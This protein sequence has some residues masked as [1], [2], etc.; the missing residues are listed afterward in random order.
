MKDKLKF[1]L[2]EQG[3]LPTIDNF[4]RLPQ[5][6]N[7]LVSGCRGIAPAPVKRMVIKSYLRT[8]DLNWFIETGTHL[9]DTLADVA[10]DKSLQTVSIELAD[11]YYH[12]AQKRFANYTNVEL[13]HGDSGTLMPQ[14]VARLQEPA[15]FWLDGHYSGGITA[16]GDLETPVSHELQAILASPVRG[17]VILIDD[18]RCF[19]GT[20][21]YPY[22][23]DFLAAIR[24][25]GRYHVEVSADILRMTPN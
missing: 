2:S 8:Y 19:D 20:H 4:R 18:I 15:L 6:G 17:H 25:D 9:G 11:S 24:T 23:D 21:D 13:L 7:W 1:I 22:L 12:T 5:I 16:R 10:F 3:I 14:V